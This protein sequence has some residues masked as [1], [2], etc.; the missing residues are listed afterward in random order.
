[1]V[2]GE[3]KRP[4]DVGRKHSRRYVVCL[5]FIQPLACG[6]IVHAAADDDGDVVLIMKVRFP[7]FWQAAAVRCTTFERGFLLAC[8]ACERAWIAC[9]MMGKLPDYSRY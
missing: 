9:V 4:T 2:D 5:R 3:R 6:C 7:A 1:M 8:A